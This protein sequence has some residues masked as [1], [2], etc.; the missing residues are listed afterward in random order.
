MPT[1]FIMP[2]FD[3]DQETAT[4]VEWLKKE[5]DYVQLDEPVL[6]VE[7]DKVAIEVLSPATGRLAQ[8]QA[9]PGEVVPVATV[10]AYILADDESPDDLPSVSPP[11][12][13]EAEPAV[14]QPDFR[15]ED[16]S[17]QSTSPTT[18]KEAVVA[19]PVAMRMAQSMGIDLSR[20]PAS[21]GRV[22]KADVERFVQ[23]SEPEAGRV[24][25][26]ATPAAR[27][28]VVELGIPLEAVM[29]S[30][31]NGRVQA[32]DVTRYANSIK[33][34]PEVEAPGVER[35]AEKVPLA[36]IRSTIA[37][38]MQA[39][40]HE[41]PHIALTVE[42]DV[43]Q[44][45]ATRARM[46]DLATQLGQRKI[47]ITALLVRIVAW[48]LARN[49]LI[50]ASLL[51]DT[52]YLWED[53]NIGVATAI[54]QGLIVPVIRKASLRTVSEINEQLKDLT[55]RAQANRL[56]LEDVKDGTFTLSNLGMFGIN[57]FRAIINPPESAILAVGK[58]L[59]KP[60]VLN[61]QDEV[62]VRPVMSMTLSA[63]HR[64]IDGVVAARFLADLVQA[65]ETPD[66]LLF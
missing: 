48:A 43:T 32:Q 47:S 30:G 20:I 35:A 7:T 55:E 24:K 45:E 39:S 46:N 44:L 9:E 58:V 60:I 52:I 65:I 33:V 64:V 21:Q 25:I 2:K 28:L 4:V 16:R 53:V 49:P 40:F 56:G 19:T 63:D 17:S 54:E 26:P 14:P 22:A 3:M 6:V 18:Q 31:P 50:N 15:Q 13:E 38:R 66:L 8:I 61:E 51:E 41:A 62:A 5:G 34:A 10:I 23:L 37:R 57:Q 12:K 29:G 42:V 11:P 59:R 1:V 27:R 36:G